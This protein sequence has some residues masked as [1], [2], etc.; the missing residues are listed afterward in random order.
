MQSSWSNMALNAP[1][2]ISVRIGRDPVAAHARDLR[3]H[4]GMLLERSMGV[5]GFMQWFANA[6]WDVDLEG[7]DDT[8]DLMSLVELRLA[9]LTSGYISDDALIEV[10]RSDFADEG[11]ELAD[12][13]WRMDAPVGHTVTMNFG[14]RTPEVK[15]LA[16]RDL[17]P[18]PAGT[19]L[20][21]E[22]A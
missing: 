21:W 17:L 5:R 18:A 1:V 22:F 6:K 19:E 4:L 11:I 8:F 2:G 15:T 7:D 13:A 10:L 3:S 16:P 14:C 9:E 20:V 12:P